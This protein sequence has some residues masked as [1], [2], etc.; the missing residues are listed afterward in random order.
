MENGKNGR[1]SV[2]A[3]A[4]G[5]PSAKEHA[6]LRWP[7]PG[8]P[9]HG[10]ITQWPMHQLIIHW[11]PTGTLLCNVPLGAPCKA[12]EE[13]CKRRWLGFVGAF[14]PAAGRHVVLE[15]TAGAACAL[16]ELLVADRSLVGYR[17]STFRL[18]K[19]KTS[20]VSAVLEPPIPGGA[21]PKPIDYATVICRLFGLESLPWGTMPMFGEGGAK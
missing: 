15:I 3:M 6:L 13:H 18:G 1:A 4:N 8:R 16:P 12:C 11:T 19:S 7:A 5:P 10:V 17:L 21:V 9:C 14:D 2:I 20:R